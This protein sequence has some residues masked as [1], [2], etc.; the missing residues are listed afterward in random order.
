M[1]EQE[2]RNQLQLRIAATGPGGERLLTEV[3]LAFREAIRRA[4]EWETIQAKKK[5][6][7]SV[8]TEDAEV[9]R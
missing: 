2:P 3:A 7:R 6:C 4:L 9:P 8:D 1:S 5:R